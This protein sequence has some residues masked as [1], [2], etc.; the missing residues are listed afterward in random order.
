MLDMEIFVKIWVRVSYAA[1]CQIDQFRQNRKT[2][3]WIFLT[4]GIQTLPLQAL[5]IH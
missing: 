3:W 2:F 4:F 1:K 5:S